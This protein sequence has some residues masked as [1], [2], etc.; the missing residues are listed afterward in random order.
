MPEIH[1]AALMRGTGNFR[2]WKQDINY[3]LD[4]GN[5]S[6]PRHYEEPFVQVIPVAPR[7]SLNAQYVHSIMEHICHLSNELTG[8]IETTGLQFYDKPHWTK[9]KNNKTV[10]LP[11]PAAEIL[12]LGITPAHDTQ[13]S[14]CFYPPHF[15]HLRKYLESK[16]IKWAWHNGKFDVKFFHNLPEPINARVDDDTM[17]LSYTL[18]E[19]GGIHD[20]ETVGNDVLHAP[21]YK[22]MIQ[23][24]LPNKDSSYSL[25][26]PDVLAEYQAKDT[27]NTARI[28][29]IYRSRV[30]RDPQLNTLY[31]KTLIPA[32]E[33]LAWVESN[34]ICVDQDRINENEKFF[35]E[36]QDTQRNKLQQI[37]GPSFNPGS[38]QQVAHLLFRRMKLPNKDKGS[39]GESTLENLREGAHKLAKIRK[40]SPEIANEQIQIITDILAYRKATKMFGTYVKGLRKWISSDGRIH[41]NYKIHGTRTGRL[42]SAEPNMQNPPRLPQIRGSFVAEEGKELLEMDLSQAE[43]RSLATVSGDPILCAIYNSGG[44]LHGDLAANLFDGWEQRTRAAKGS[45]EYQLAYEQRVKCKNVNFGIIYGITAFGLYDQIGGPTTP[46]EECMEMIDGWYNRYEVAGEFIGKCRGAPAKNQVMTTCFGRKKRVGL[47]SGSNIHHLRNE[48]ANFPHQSIASDITLQTAIRVWK[49]LREW[50][51]KIVNLVHDSIIMEVPIT[52]SDE[53]RWRVI[54]YVRNEFEQVPRDWGLTRVPFVSDAE[55]GQRWGSLIDP[56]ELKEAA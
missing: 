39:T 2:Q 27:C 10:L 55:V 42:S 24:Y 23:P 9:T 16:E 30:A 1:V 19:E 5:G 29:S 20:L 47:V 56:G 43:L 48:A 40:Q 46:L 11:Q 21:D 18:D 45:E 25:V 22:Y 17:L 31:I 53:L 51:V 28:R 54:E 6:P 41:S 38:P 49:Q 13:I 52:A 8:D 34:G 15:K 50:D 3:A 26:P 35:R 32:S 36:M 7:D 37:I 33:M 14:Y 44:D 12:S 4:M